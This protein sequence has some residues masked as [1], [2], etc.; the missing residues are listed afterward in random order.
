VS[1]ADGYHLWSEAYDRTLTDVFALQEEVAH[2]VVAALSLQGYGLERPPRIRPPTGV[3]E[4][5]TL[6]LRGRYFVLKGDTESLRVGL[7]YFDQALELDPEYALAHAGVAQCWAMRGFEE[8]GD[9][10]PLEAMPKAKAAADRSLALD[11]QLPEGHAWRGIIAL[12]F[13][14]DPAEAEARLTRAIELQPSTIAARLWLAILRS[15]SGRHEEAIAE[16]L[17]A[18]RLD[19]VAIRVQ[20]VLGRCYYWA[21]RFEEA[22]RRFQTVLGMDPNSLA[23]SWVARVF[24]AT[25][26][27]DLGLHTVET[28]MARLGRHPL[29]L[30]SQ[31]ICLARLDR[32][33]EARRVIAEL[34]ELAGM[35]YVTPFLAASIHAHLG[36]EEAAME[37][38]EEAARQRSGFLPFAP[39]LLGGRSLRET[40]GFKALMQRL[41][42]AGAEAA[43]PGT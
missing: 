25:G 21:G 38:L 13:D 36:E 2:A 34:E 43:S 30:E 42:L 19:P 12:L 28:A 17:Q 31:G 10:A 33:N 22:M 3:I 29:L 16:V 5:Y 39:L 40:A 6:Y 41:G 4:A 14:Y 15:T 18:E 20:F 8:F 9:L 26:R 35:R 11:P 24:V 7:E 32:A 23:C 27:A 1:A 37:C